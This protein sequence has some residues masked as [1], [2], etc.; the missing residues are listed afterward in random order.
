[1]EG[2][3]FTP[4]DTIQMTLLTIDI[5]ALREDSCVVVLGGSCLGEFCSVM[6]LSFY[7]KTS[8]IDQK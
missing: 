8:K 5:I 4:M 6:D 7:P 1:M 2:F 3:S